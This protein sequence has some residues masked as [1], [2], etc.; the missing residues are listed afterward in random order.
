MTALGL[1]PGWH[2]KT[3]PLLFIFHLSLCPRLFSPFLL[4]FTPLLIVCWVHPATQRLQEAYG[5]GWEL[6]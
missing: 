4:A 2:W 6:M 1:V 3:A 5:Q